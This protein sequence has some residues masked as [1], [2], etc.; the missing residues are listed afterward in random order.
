MPLMMMGT[1][2]RPGIDDDRTAAGKGR[3]RAGRESR[4]PVSC[5]NSA[6]IQ[7]PI[8]CSSTT[9]T[10]CARYQG[11]RRRHQTAGKPNAQAFRL[12][13]FARKDRETLT[14]V[15][16]ARH[17]CLGEHGRTMVS[18]ADRD[19]ERGRPRPAGRDWPRSAS[20]RTARSAPRSP[21]TTPPSR[22]S[23]RSRTA[24]HSRARPPGSEACDT[25]EHQQRRRA[26]HAVHQSDQ[27]RAPAKAMLVACGRARMR[28]GFAGMAVGMQMHRAVAMAVPMKMH[29]VAPQ[30]PQHMRA[31]A[32]QHD[33]DGGLDRPRQLVRRSR[34]RAGSRRRRRRTASAYG[35]T[36]RSGRA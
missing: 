16:A 29:A 18:H 32:D 13:Q 12:R 2:G 21:S 28:R 11:L 22:S 24:R 33:A 5:Q 17:P 1:P 26:G 7:I 15:T 10:E 9:L 30:P 8:S 27:Q 4:S 3:R 36:P 20:A 35:R 31:E 6:W 14:A 34:G 23:S 19:G 25:V